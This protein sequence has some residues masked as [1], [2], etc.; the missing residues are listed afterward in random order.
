[1]TLC[2]QILLGN[3]FA[4]NDLNSRLPLPAHDD[5]LPGDS[6]TTVR[7]NYEWRIFIVRILEGLQ[8]YNNTVI[9]DAELDAFN[10]VYHSLL[11]DLYT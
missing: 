9:D 8:E 4:K 2:Q 6:R 3:F 10:Q 11:D 1:M 5:I 7:L